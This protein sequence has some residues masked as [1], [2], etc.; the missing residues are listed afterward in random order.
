MKIDSL[1]QRFNLK[2]AQQLSPSQNG[3]LKAR[4][5]QGQGVS[6]ADRVDISQTSKDIRKIQSILK[7]TPDVR[8]DKVRAIKEQIEA[9]TYKIDAKKVANAMMVDLLKVLI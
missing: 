9:G 5:T 2:G 8:A 3:T 7:T 4:Q 6:L 1:Y